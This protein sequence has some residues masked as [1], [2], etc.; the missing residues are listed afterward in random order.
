MGTN[1]YTTKK[2]THCETCGQKLPKVDVVYDV[3]LGKSSYGWAFTIQANGYKLYKNWD[4]MKVWLKGKK[5]V[6]EYDEPVTVAQFIKLV[7]NKKDVAD[8][9]P[10]DYGN[11][12][13]VIG[14]YKFMDCEFS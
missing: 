7:E 2:Q 12:L 14:G 1:Y 8:P 5:I 4:E 13:K 3:H 6:N 10:V 11:L 9:E